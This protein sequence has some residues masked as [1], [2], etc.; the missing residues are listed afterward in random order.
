MVGTSAQKCTEERRTK[1]GQ[2]QL[3]TI[4]A[5]FFAIDTFEHYWRA[6]MKNCILFRLSPVLL[7][8]FLVSAPVFAGPPRTLTILHTNDMHATFVP[9]EAM[10]VKT[11]PRPMVGGFAELNFVA[12]SVR[13]GR[14]DVLMMDAGD[15]MTGNPI[16]E[17]IYH[18]A[19]G[20]ALFEMMNMMGYDVW[21]PGNHD[22]D[23][24]QD[25]LRGLVSIARFPTVS[26]NLR[27]DR[28][29]FPLGNRPYIILE[30]GG[31]RIGII[32]I[33]SQ[34]LSSLVNQNNLVGLRVLSPVETVQRYVDELDPKTDLLIALT[35]QGADE[36]S[37]MAMQVH[38]LDVIVGGHSHTR[39]KKPRLVND[40]IIVQTGSNTENLG[41]LDLTVADDRVVHYDGRLIP[42]WAG[43]ERPASQVGIFAD[44]LQ[45]EIE[46]EYSEVIGV[47]R[48][49][50]IR[51]DT[52]TAFASF[53]TEAQRNAV[54]A[55]VAFM[56]VHGIRKDIA[57]GPM[58]KRDLF[59][60]LPF[61]NV[62]TTFQLSGKEL[63]RVL[64]HA[65]KTRQA[66]YMTGVSGAWRKT[67]DST[68][69]WSDL[70]VGSS[71]IDEQRQYSCT[72]SDYLVGE[73]H[74]YLGIDPVNII[75]LSRTLFDTVEKAVRAEH[76]IQPRVAATVRRAP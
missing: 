47:L 30:R 51:R 54:H 74:R 52:L 22:L 70:R 49:D 9:R 56:N 15:V 59:E 69:I 35:H 10:W 17:R 23:I 28:M 18:G 45:K 32:G 71:P 19:S 14:T 46:K 64:D 3:S 20:G 8:A 55:D 2:Y 13:A 73:A 53:V 65:V 7:F 58:T 36:D 27:D 41:V 5:I 67:A 63:R 29:G 72:A 21:S 44:S 57:A 75:F 60:A 26:A 43:R 31:L 62:L 50:W 40:V 12:D 34:E 61:R 33:M 76:D 25:N 66:I 39:L 68:V 11:T 42:L 6:C 1:Q 24:S 16:T 4:L 38:G 48:A 37:A